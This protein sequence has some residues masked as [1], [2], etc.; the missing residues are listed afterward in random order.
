MALTNSD[1]DQAFLG[2]Y[3]RPAVDADRS[4]W[5]SGSSTVSSM[6]TA[7]ETSP[8]GQVVQQVVRLYQ[9]AFNRAPDESGF[10]FWVQQ[11]NSAALA[12][13]PGLFNADQIA[14]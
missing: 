9:A 2:I 7:L 3:R 6:L 1:V 5:T 12:P 11:A 4:Y 13:T 10:T 8:E 14:L